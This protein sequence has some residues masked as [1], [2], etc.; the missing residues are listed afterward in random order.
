MTLDHDTGDLNMSATLI[1]PNEIETDKLSPLHAVGCVQRG[2]HGGVLFYLVNKE[3][4]PKPEPLPKGVRTIQ[5]VLAQ[6]AAEL[7]AEL[8]K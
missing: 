5:D 6:I 3:E 4:K 2:L 7:E 8:R 1:S